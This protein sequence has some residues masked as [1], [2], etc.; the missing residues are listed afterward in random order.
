VIIIFLFYYFI[1]YTKKHHCDISRH[2]Y[3]ALCSNSMPSITL[4]YSPFFFYSFEGFYYSIFILI[5]ISYSPF[6]ITLSFHL[7]LLIM[8][9]ICLSDSALLFHL[10]WWSPSPLCKTKPSKHMS[11]WLRVGGKVTS[12]PNHNTYL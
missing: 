11:L 2:A 10:T 12:Y 5:L 9:D 6:P 4:S 8:C 1:S 3:N 7:P